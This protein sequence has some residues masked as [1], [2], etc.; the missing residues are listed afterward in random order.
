MGGHL[1]FRSKLGWFCGE[2][3]T[4][5]GPSTGFGWFWVGFVV[6]TASEQNIPSWRKTSPLLQ[7]RVKTLHIETPKS[8][9]VFHPFLPK[10]NPSASRLFRY[11][12]RPQEEHRPAARPRNTSKSSLQL[13]PTR[14]FG[15]LEGQLGLAWSLGAW[16]CSFFFFFWG[17][18]WVLCLFFSPPTPPSFCDDNKNG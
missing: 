18:G 14:R 1:D 16:S 17:G 7:Y 3:T 4:F 15:L 10:S 8:N 13:R 11:P 12:A 9:H 5:W 6:K 2:K